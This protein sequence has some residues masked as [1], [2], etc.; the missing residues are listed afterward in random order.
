MP[1]HTFAIKAGPNPCDCEIEMDGKKLVGVTRVSLDLVGG[2]PTLLK[3]EIMGE[4][5]VEGGFKESAIIKVEQRV[6]H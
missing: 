4:I 5:R 2:S 6:G 3:L 1:L